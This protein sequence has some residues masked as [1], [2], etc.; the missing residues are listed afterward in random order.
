MWNGGD[1]TRRARHVCT[2]TN[3]PQN[4][5]HCTCRDEVARKMASSFI[6]L[7]WSSLPDA[8]VPNKW[9]KLW[10][11]LEFVAMGLI[12]LGLLPR[13]FDLAFKKM[14][15][16]EFESADHYKIDPKLV[17]SIAY[18]AVNGVRL[19]KSTTFLQDPTTKHVVPTLL[20]LSEPLRILT[21]YWLYC[22]NVCR[23]VENPPIFDLLDKRR[24]PPWALQ[25]YLANMLFDPHGTGRLQLIWRTFDAI[26]YDDFLETHTDC[27]RQLRRRLMFV[28]CWIHRRHQEYFNF[29]ILWIL[30][31]ADNNA[32]PS[33]LRLA[34]ARWDSCNECCLPPGMLRRL[35]ARGITS[36]DLQ[37]PKWRSIFLAIARL[38][39]LTVADVECKH[40]Q[41][42]HFRGFA[43]FPSIVAAFIN[44]ESKASIHEAKP[45][46][47]PGGALAVAS[48]PQQNHVIVAAGQGST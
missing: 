24:S 12:I 30:A 20:V 16:K 11:P 33:F 17:E 45:Q 36:T 27:V 13:A 35:K 21:G 25:Q 48:P 9:N 5:R 19:K 2:I 39:Q 4:Q 3:K 43:P 15:F 40:S 18:H 22:L 46:T 47:P 34:L 29:R 28:S 14:I 38:L 44:N 41:N 37:S 42:N 10:D 1:I 8:P 26:D 7:V 23:S 32:D 31:I 6:D